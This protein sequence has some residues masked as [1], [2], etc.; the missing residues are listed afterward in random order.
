MISKIFRSIFATSIV[1]LFATLVI[2]TSFLYDYFT[3][4]H[5][6]QIKDE[7]STASVGTEQSGEKYLENL[8][9]DN[10]RLT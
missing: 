5:I 10:F 4:I 9:S 7:L 3:D 2:I 1:V 6:N 8:K